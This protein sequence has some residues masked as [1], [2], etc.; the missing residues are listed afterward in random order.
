GDG[1]AFGDGL[2][3][4]GGSVIRLTIAGSGSNGSIDFGPSLAGAGGWMAGQSRYFQVWYRDPVGG[5]CGSGYNLT[6][7]IAVDFTN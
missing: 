1:V 4:V 2:R 7:G 3:C 6:N 5:P